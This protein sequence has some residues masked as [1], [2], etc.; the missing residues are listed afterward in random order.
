MEKPTL[1]TIP[2]KDIPDA[3]L[4]SKDPNEVIYWIGKP[5][6]AFAYGMSEGAWKWV[7]GDPV[8]VIVVSLSPLL[9]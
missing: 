7:I 8:V 1:T 3:I 4:L 6:D 9:E 5:D 2:E